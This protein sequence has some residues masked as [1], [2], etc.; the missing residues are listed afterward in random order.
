MQ[1]CISALVANIFYRVDCNCHKFGF[2]I[3]GNQSDWLLTKAQVYQRRVEH[4]HNI[5]PW[6]VIENPTDWLLTKAQV[7]QRRVEHKHNIE[8][9][10]V[11]ENPTDW[12]LTKAQVHQRRVEHKHNIEPWIVIEN[13]TDWLLTKAQVHQRRVEH[14]HNIEPLIVIENPTGIQFNNKKNNTVNTEYCST[15][16]RVGS[17]TFREPTGEYTYYYH[18]DDISGCVPLWKLNMWTQPHCRIGSACPPNEA[19]TK[20]V[21]NERASIAAV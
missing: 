21:T 1:A 16:H 14:K 17:Y 15:L 7:H 19:A 6:I 18:G 12:L 2:S 10:I 8:P 5:E 20:G 11:I 9:W 3:G 13:P 4:K